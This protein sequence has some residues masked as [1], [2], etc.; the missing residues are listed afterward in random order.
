MLPVAVHP[1]GALRHRR[2]PPYLVVLALGMFVAVVGAWCAGGVARPAAGAGSAQILLD[3][4]PAAPGVQ[5]Q[6]TVPYGT[7]P[8]Q[9]DVVV[10]NADNIGAFE[11][12][13]AYDNV[14]LAFDSWTL[15]PFLG[16]TGRP[17]SCF[18]IISENTIR[19]GCTTTGIEPAGPSGD[20]V[21]VH[22]FFHPRFSGQTCMSMLLVETAEILGH[23]LPTTG[24]GGCVTIPPPTPTPTP[25]PTATL[26][27]TATRTPPTPTRTPR[28]SSPTPVPTTPVPQT[29]GAT[30][31]PAASA[32]P[33][34]ASATAAPRTPPAGTSTLA[35]VNTVISAERTPSLTRTVA[36][37][38]GFPGTGSNGG[39]RASRLEWV[40]AVMGLIIG[41]LLVTLLRQSARSDDG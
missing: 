13:L 23:P 7:D 38:T 2:S 22:L 36:P 21:L 18:P 12:Y 35:V 4:D 32:T 5:A 25:S 3:F 37:G 33:P 15:G 29:P 30:T 40:V 6:A 8:V 19:I 11:F 10:L 34:T 26:T 14:S 31:T 24:A 39:M 9:V 17:V 41:V 20:G 16:S 27:P 1:A 28:T